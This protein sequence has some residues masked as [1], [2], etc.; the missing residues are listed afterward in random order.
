MGSGRIHLNPPV[1]RLAVVPFHKDLTLDD[2]V[3]G[4]VV[5]GCVAGKILSA[6]G[7]FKVALGFVFG[8]AAN[9]AL[10]QGTRTFLLVMV[11]DRPTLC[12]ADLN[13]ICLSH[14]SR[15]RF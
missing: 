10:D 15:T 12:A 9:I 8:N 5:M 14:G 2:L 11:K 3:S 6:L 1:C 13:G 7:A 4:A